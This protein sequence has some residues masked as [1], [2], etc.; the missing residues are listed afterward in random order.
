MSFNGMSNIRG[1][2]IWD[3]DQSGPSSPQIPP[4]SPTPQ[5][6]TL[7]PYSQPSS[8]VCRSGRLRTDASRGSSACCWVPWG[9]SSARWC[10]P[11]ASARHPETYPETGGERTKED[12]QDG[13]RKPHAL[14]GH[15]Q[16]FHQHVIY[17]HLT[18]YA[19]WTTCEVILHVHRRGYLMNCLHWQRSWW[20]TIVVRSELVLKTQNMT[21]RH[22]LK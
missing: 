15:Q 9:L 13:K 2:W 4:P 7:S 12:R 11:G 14:A 6:C 1:F 3:I 22:S 19:N 16:P 20:R 17:C 18:V 10:W 8:L 5:P 21:L